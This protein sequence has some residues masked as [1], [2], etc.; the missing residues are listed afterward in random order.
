[1]NLKSQ[2]TLTRVCR[3]NIKI[4]LVLHEEYLKVLK[5]IH[6]VIS[7]WTVLA[8]PSPPIL[9]PKENATQLRP[10]CCSL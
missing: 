9:L 2:V 7:L 10:S 6:F 4:A 1:M 3:E 8:P 5:Q